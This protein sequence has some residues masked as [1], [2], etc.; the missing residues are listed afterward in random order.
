MTYARARLWLGITSVGTWVVISTAALAFGIP[1]RVFPDAPSGIFDDVAGLAL[2]VAVSLGIGFV[3]D[4]LGGFV[5]PRRFERSSTG[6]AEWGIGWGRGVLSFGFGTVVFGLTVMLLARSFGF[7][8]AIVAVAVMS[9][10]LVVVQGPLARQVGRLRRHRETAAAARGHDVVRNHDR[11]FTG[12]WVGWP[13]RERLLI[14]ATWLEDLTPEQ[15]EAEIRRRTAVLESGSR[16]RGVWLGVS[17]NLLGFGL[18]AT[19][20]GLDLGSVAGIVSASL[21]MTLWSF[22]GALMLPSL[23]RPAVYGADR[24]ARD[25]GTDP[26]TL[27]ATMQRLDQLQDDEPDRP[28]GVETVFH[29]IPALRRRIAR[30]EEGR[31]SE[32]GAWHAARMALF[33]SWASFGLL[34][35]AVHCNCGRPELWVLLPA[36]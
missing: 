8:G 10:L 31:A 2:A 7:A 18:V 20:T 5:L 14:P 36:D 30:L 27:V 22:L 29:P 12:G 9:L 25:T 28:I 6:L 3:F 16:S 33:L 1:A 32:G 13:G 15:L 17:F 19:L 26:D 34:G 24:R 11:G 35:R 4:L 21:W 23:S